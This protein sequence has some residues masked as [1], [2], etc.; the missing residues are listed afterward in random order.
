MWCNSSFGKTKEEKKVL[1]Q[2]NIIETSE[3]NVHFSLSTFF[4][5]DLLFCNVCKVNH[6]RGSKLFRYNLS[7]KGEII[8]HNFTNFFERDI[9][10]ET[11]SALM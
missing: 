4:H 9:S 6:C 11:L 7:T 10:Q 2:L 3:S 5:F 8:C 1:Q